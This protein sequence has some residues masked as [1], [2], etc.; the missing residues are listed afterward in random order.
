M[1]CGKRVAQRKLRGSMAKAESLGCLHHPS[2]HPTHQLQELDKQATKL[3]QS[4]FP[5]GSMGSQQLPPGT[6]AGL[7]GIASG[8]HVA[9]VSVYLSDYDRGGCWHLDRSHP[10][11]TS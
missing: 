6:S 9:H 3:C 5:P 4:S 1:I 7:G 2:V 10:G 11:V 8:P